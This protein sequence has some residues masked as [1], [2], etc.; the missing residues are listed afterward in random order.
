MNGPALGLLTGTALAL[1]SGGAGAALWVLVLVLISGFYSGSETA[2]VSARRVLL[3]R[4]AA[5]GRNDARTALR[6]LDDAPRTI[7]TTLVGTNLATVAAS[8]LATAFFGGIS[9]EHGAAL[10]TLTVTPIALFVGE[11]LPKAL[12]RSHATLLLR[13]LSG[14]LRASVVLLSPLVGL[15]GGMTRGLL[16]LLRIPAAER[17]PLFRR[18]D[19]GHVFLHAVAMEDAGAGAGVGSTMRMARKALDLKDR[20]VRDAMVQLPSDWGVP[21]SAGVGE[22][23]ERIRTVRP[24]FLAVLDEAGR[25]QGFVAPKALLGVPLDRTLAELVRP[26]YVL[27][28]D[29][30][31][32]NAIGGFR[33]SQQSVGLVRGREGQ[34]LGVV[35]AED[36]LEE[37]V[38]ELWSASQDSD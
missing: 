32:D 10:A 9:P 2:L 24:R 23:I 35:T 16:W 25:V 11:I 28:P 31:L 15:A 21:G 18:E 37:V 12:F 34:T 27:N 5:G 29:D 22:A 8:S 13:V 19:L 14:T 3:D 30:P 38:G 7:A 4:L 6:L 20:R 1:G 33:R 17:R 26:A 36:V